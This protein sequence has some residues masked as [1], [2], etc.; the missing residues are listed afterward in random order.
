MPIHIARELHDKERVF[1]PYF[2][3]TVCFHSS[4][5]SYR[6]AETVINA[7]Y[8]RCGTPS[9]ISADTI[10]RCT[11]AE[12][13]EII[14]YKYQEATNILVAHG[15]PKT[16]IW[17][18]DQ[19]LPENLKNSPLNGFTIDPVSIMV[20]ELAAQW[21]PPLPNDISA[22]GSKIYSQP[23]NSTHPPNPGRRGSR[24]LIHENQRETELIHYTQWINTNQ[25]RDPFNSFL[26]PCSFESNVE[27]VLYITIDAIMLDS[28][29]SIHVKGG[30]HGSRDS[31]ERV[32]H[33]NIVIQ[34]G[35][36]DE[37]YRI[38]SVSIDEAFRQLIAFLLVN[39]LHRRYMI[40]FTDGETTIFTAI[41]T[42]F[43]QW[44]HKCY[45]DP[46]HIE[47]K[48]YTLLSL[49]L[50]STRVD[51]PW[52]S[53]EII[54]GPGKSEK[55]SISRLY[56][57][58]LMNILWWGNVDEA[59]YYI[60]HIDPSLVKNKT[61]LNN[62]LT[63][64]STDERKGKGKYITCYAMRKKAG[65]LN[66]SNSVEGENEVIVGERQKVDERMFWT[67]QGSGPLAS[68]TCIFANGEDM[69]WFI[70]GHFSFK[71]NW[72]A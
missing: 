42:Y 49:A 11:L 18:K 59:K 60:E 32:K 33:W 27:S 23:D 66:S 62:L 29:S 8:H 15:F 50:I 45:L 5:S 4:T 22:D 39:E 35:E 3:H 71:K 54:S 7:D 57:R 58:R 55:T 21:P 14:R 6:K 34:R 46:Y 51:D 52:H 10:R 9:T 37:R 1:S 56:G 67:V 20:P 53:K 25:D 44:H 68:L 31:N 28:Q 2:A 69:D 61:A 64:I 48:I 26:H 19:E 43:S 40:F 13:K 17:P 38:T 12:G 41:D 72:A 70:K 30:K 63:Y 47:E 36:S 16:G 65:L 24:C